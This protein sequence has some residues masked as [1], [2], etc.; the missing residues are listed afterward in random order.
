MDTDGE[1]TRRISK[2]EGYSELLRMEHEPEELTPLE[3]N[4]EAMLDE[5]GRM[6]AVD[7]ADVG[8]AFIFRV[9]PWSR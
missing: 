9:D 1:T 8:L 7:V 4:V 5:L 2:L 6:W 3:G